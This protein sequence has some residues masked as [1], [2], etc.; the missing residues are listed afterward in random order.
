MKRTFTCIICPNSCEIEAEY[1]PGSHEIGMTGAGCRRGEAYVR[2][3]LIAPMRT[4][5]SSV[6]LRNG[7]LPLASVRLDRPV[8]REQIPAVMDEIKKIC[9]DAPVHAGDVVIPD[10]LGSGSNVIITK[11]IGRI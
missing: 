2:Q 5:A 10:V 7:E 3:E 9:L 11:N 8:P 4:I 1:T 6:R